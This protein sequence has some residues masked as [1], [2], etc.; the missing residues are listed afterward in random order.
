[1]KFQG[2]PPGR[3][4]FT[5]VPNVVFSE[6][7]PLMDDAAELQVTLRV[8]YLLSQKKGSPRYVTEHELRADETLMRALEFNPQN[9]KRGL[10]KAIAHGALLQVEADGAAWYFFNTPE[11]RKAL[12]QIERGEFKSVETTRLVEPPAEPTPNIFKLYEQHI[13][14]LTPLIAEELKEAEQEYPP[15]VILDAFRIAVENNAR[16]WRYVNK[17]LSDWTRRVRPT[18]SMRD[19]KTRRPASR[20]RR[21]TI[22]GKLADVAKPK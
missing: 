6:L 3:L 17:I 18:R 8:F 11:G 19:E 14:A 13:G 20:Q 9:L 7:L 1:M 22:T 10:E 16:S 2:V 21:P 4:T 15:E 5:S 12:E